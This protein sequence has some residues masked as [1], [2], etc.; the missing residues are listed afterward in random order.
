[1]KALKSAL[2]GIVLFLLLGIS[3]NLTAQ[4]VYVTKTGKK[5]HKSDCRYLKQSKEA[6]SLSDAKAKN[7]TACKVCKPSTEVTKT[8]TPKATKEST[9]ETTK[10]STTKATQ[11]TATTQAGSRCKRKTTNESGKCWQHE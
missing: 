8:T 5:Y 11:C 3:L 10:Q 7:Y 9:K 4:T 1:M 6:I 2:S